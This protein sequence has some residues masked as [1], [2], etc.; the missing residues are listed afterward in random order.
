MTGITDFLLESVASLGVEHSV[1]HDKLP[2]AWADGAWKDTL[3]LCFCHSCHSA[4]HRVG[5]DLTAV[6]ADIRSRLVTGPVGSGLDGLLESP[7]NLRRSIANRFLSDLN[8]VAIE[9]GARITVAATTDE[10]SY[11]SYAPVKLGAG[12]VVTGCAQLSAD[13]GHGW[14][15]VRAWLRNGSQAV[16]GVVDML[17]PATSLKGALAG[18]S[19]NASP[20]HL[21][22]DIYLYHLGLRRPSSLDG[23]RIREAIDHHRSTKGQL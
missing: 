1:A 22:N 2:F 19:D 17:P 20:I 5:V 18:P 7:R 10:R 6:S 16:A 15:D 8:E 12:S 11:G 23:L 21:L 4:G 14:D 13:G 9:I 3:S